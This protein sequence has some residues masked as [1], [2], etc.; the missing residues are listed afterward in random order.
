M[1][2]ET[3]IRP[4][5]QTHPRGPRRVFLTLA[6]ALTCGSRSQPLWPTR[7]P[8][9]RS[10]TSWPCTSGALSSSLR[11]GRS[12]HAGGPSPWLSSSPAYPKS[13]IPGRISV[14]WGPRPGWSSTQSVATSAPSSRGWLQQKWRKPRPDP[15]PFA[16]CL[17]GGGFRLRRGHKTRRDLLPR[18]SG[19]LVEPSSSPITHGN[20]PPRPVKLPIAKSDCPSLIPPLEPPCVRG[21]GLG[22]VSVGALRTELDWGVRYSLPDSRLCRRPAVRRGSTSWP[23]EHLVNCSAVVRL[24]V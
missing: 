24:A 14:V 15:H 21:V 9:A 2:L 10:L 8:G 5:S 6:R 20:A 4:S 17:G 18:L 12:G 11:T 23:S 1:G 22:R 7:S 3:S 16:V 13:I 19:P